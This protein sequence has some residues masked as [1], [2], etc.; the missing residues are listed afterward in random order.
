MSH[1]RQSSSEVSLYYPTSFPM[2]WAWDSTCDFYFQVYMNLAN[3]GDS[4]V[5]CKTIVVFV[6]PKLE[7]GVVI[8]QMD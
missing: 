8:R 2:F 7:E 4:A 1:F 6:L 3:L 5:F